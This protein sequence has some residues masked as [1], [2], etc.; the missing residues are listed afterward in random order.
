MSD[1]QQIDAANGTA[2]RE[3]VRFASGDTEY[4][5]WHHPG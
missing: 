2:R 1:Q 4:A 3:K 5:A